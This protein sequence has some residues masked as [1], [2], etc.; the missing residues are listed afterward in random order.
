M[1]T[2]STAS[3]QTTTLALALT[4]GTA[5]GGGTDYGATGATNLQVSVDK[6]A[7][8]ANATSVTI[9]ANATSVL[10]RTPVTQDARDEADETFTLTATRT[11]GTPLTN[12]G[13]AASGVATI[14]DDDPTP[15]LS[16][17]DVTVNEAAGT[18][19][20]TVTLSA[21]SG[22]TV[23]VN[24]GTGNGTAS[25]GSDYT[26]TSGTLTFSPGTTTQT[27]TVPIT[28]DTLF[29]GLPGETL[30]V[31]LSGATN[32]TIADTLGVGTIT[33]NDSAPTI[34]AV[35]SPT[36]TEGASLV[37]TVN[38]SNAS[39][40]ATTFA[41]SLGG[42]TAGTTDYGTVSF[43]NGVTLAG[44]VLTVPAG[45][46]NFTVTL[47]TT[48]DSL[49]EGSE[50]VPLSIGGTT[51]T[52]TIADNETAPT[53]SVSSTT[54]AESAGHAVFTVALSTPSALAITVALA[55]GGGTASGGGTDY[56][57]SAATN[58]Q[59]S[60]D[61]GLT[62][63]N[64]STHTFAPGVTSVLVRTPIVDDGVY[65]PGSE[66]FNLT[67][68][69]T[70]GQTAN[71][72]AT[73]TAT[74]TDNDTQPTLSVSDSYA[75]EGQNMVFTVTL[76]NPS[77]QTVTVNYATANATSGNVAT[78]TGSSRDYEP[79]SGTLTFAPGQTSLTVSVPITTLGGTNEQNEIFN[80]N[81]SA[82]SNA[83][84]ADATGVGT[85]IERVYAAADTATVYEA[86]LDT[87]LVSGTVPGS[88]AETVSGNLL[89]NDYTPSGT[90]SVNQVTFGGTNYAITA[91][92]SQTITTTLGT[93]QVYS[94]GNYI[95]T[96]NSNSTG[97]DA[98][99]EQFACRVT[100]GT[101]DSTANLTINIV[102]DAPV[103]S[104]VSHTLQAASA[105]L[106][107]NLVL[108]IDVSGSMAWDANG[109]SSG[110]A[111]FDP[112]TVR[113][114]IAK[115][116][117][118]DLIERF[119]GLGNVNVQIVSF[120]SSANESAWFNDNSRAAIDYVNGL[121][122]NGGT[123]YS[124]AL[125]AVMTDFSKPPADKTLFYFVSDGEPTDGYAV[126]ATQQTAWQNFVAAQGTATAPSIA[127]GVGI[128]EATLD[129]L[130]PVAYPNV[131]ANGDGAEDYA[132]KVNNP[133]DLSSTLL[134]TVDGGVVL[135]NVS[136]L[137]G[138]GTSGLILGADGGQVQSI[139]VDGTTYSYTAGGPQLV[140]V[141]TL[142]GGV[143]T[144]NFVTGRYE[145]H[146]SVNQTIQGQQEVFRVTGVDGDGDSKAINLL[147]N[148]DYVANLDANRDQVITNISDGSPI[149]I[150]AEA[151]LH[152]DSKSG[153]TALTGVSGAQG[154]TVSGTTTVLFDPA[155]GLE[156][157]A[158][159]SYVTE[160]SAG[161]NTIAAAVDLSNRSAFGPLGAADAASVV[162]PALPGLKFSGSISANSDVDYIKIRLKAG[163]RI[164]LDVDNAGLGSSLD[165]LLELRNAA[166]GVLASND[167]SGAS[168]GGGGSSNSRDS[169]LEYTATA[170]ADYYV[171]VSSYNSGSNG[172]YALWMQIDPVRGFD[173]TMSS[174]L[175]SDSAYVDVKQVSGTT[176]TGGGGD[177]I[178]IGGGSNDTISGGAG[179][180]ALYGN[181]GN[182]Q[183]Q[184]GAGHDL[185]DG[186]VGNDTLD[187]GAGLDRLVGGAGNDLLTGGLGADV[188]AWKLGDQGGAGAPALDTVVDFDTA[189]GGDRLDLR[190]LL[191][192]EIAN[193]VM[194]NLEN[195]LHFE[196][197]GTN[198]LIHI[199]STGGFS[200]D[201]H[202]I[203]GSFS[204]GQENQTITLQGVDLTAGFST[205]QQIIQDLLNKGKLITD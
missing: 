90:L 205:D 83:T 107:Y 142:K 22:Q 105:S 123:R 177:E 199:S 140:T 150:S 75:R 138:G 51:G 198:T 69:R 36:V 48:Q 56:G 197:S 171:R 63:N 87:T 160:T 201:A 120:S 15:T 76:S 183:L 110:Q 169:Y 103:G 109:R 192:G 72:A 95:Y 7:T 174:G 152:N 102:D 148:L 129:P 3:S 77:A 33:D 24:Y 41:Y 137:S 99:A 122:P 175:A 59:V 116:A 202:T 85:I 45:V 128:G 67:A 44:G 182:D 124:T 68:T 5:T 57:A 16:V 173:Y 181:V 113:M 1:L 30:N 161:N 112:N 204:N 64:A 14:T 92:G 154:G 80:L 28:N 35:S 189:S 195:F 66:T 55:L 115:A 8:W 54:L 203:G 26:A 10:V 157:G 200:G 193:P 81:L 19:T 185:L 78:G 43:S 13:G 65:E 155:N 79:T 25:A 151:L 52:G 176:L 29:E 114:D 166:G 187:G 126:N 130:R 61:G 4:A 39:T 156:F 18:M 178:L 165:S 31:T 2:L 12:A 50:S 86:A 136:V 53:L 73:G 162:N 6:G 172:A 37:Y 108:V 163:E 117:L 111:G 104:D 145:Y 179:N 170:E 158:A 96:L 186:G 196:K 106:T 119:D 134:A 89:G 121:Q 9:P 38:L 21:A 23:T 94:N 127:F 167:D 153:T 184:G 101:T 93:L 91:G 34:T 149:A 98:V 62:W 49:F 133:T 74:I 131:D 125:D 190:D 32:A 40:T 143:L 17:N 27:I 118:A 159:A 60:T 132:I 141:D 147:I 46:T 82:P 188:F 146:L 100:N 58:L 42:G 194:Q 70:G 164:V 20:F 180:D 88:T 47:P 11:A 135:G 97:G 168:F 191:Q 84:I 71:A 144:V 139:V